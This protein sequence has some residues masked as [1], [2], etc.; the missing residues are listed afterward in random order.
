MSNQTRTVFGY[1]SILFSYVNPIFDCKITV[2]AL[3]VNFKI[4]KIIT[5]VND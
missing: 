2:T 3:H 4:R 5:D 1:L